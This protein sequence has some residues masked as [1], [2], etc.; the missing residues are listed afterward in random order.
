MNEKTIEL[1][2]MTYQFDIEKDCWKLRLAKSQTSIKDFRQLALITERTDFFVPAEV[3]EEHDVYVF[4]FTVNEKM[5]KWA[6]IEK[7]GRNDKL[8]ALCNV[9]RFQECLPT[10]TTFFLHPD[11]LVF[12]DNLIPTIIYRGIRDL[13]PPFTTDSSK[14]LHQYKCLAIA[15]F[16]KKYSFDE[17]YNGSINNANETEF[18]RKIGEIAD[19][20]A[21]IKFLEANYENEQKTTERTM[22]L[23]PKK[24]FRLFKQLSIMMIALSI[25]LA[26]P[27]AYFSFVKVPYQ[28][29]LLAAHHDF[30][31]ADYGK[32]ISDLEEQKAEKLPNST[33]Y[34]LAYAYIDVEKLDPAPKSVIM[35]NISLKSDSN[36]LLYWIYNGQGKLEEST[37]LAKYMDDPVLILYGLIKQIE[38]VNSNPKLTG[39]EREEQVKSLR[40]QLE[41]Y[42]EQYNLRP[43]DDLTNPDSDYE[44]GEAEQG[45]VEEKTEP[46]NPESDE[47]DTTDEE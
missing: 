38:Q 34:I 19:V 42:R 9:G 2:S 17:L 33:K 41:N 29:K 13:V 7:L 35:R 45:D 14:F 8:R 28:N 47:V 26:A 27:L 46:D 15:L 3:E 39:S 16:S 25:I 31:A 11:N 18:E 40:E 32:V 4:S 21:L 10:R 5:K 37:D 6:D 12:N 1:E 44:P 20:S 24:Q 43:E 36:Y 30:L 22:Q 23:V